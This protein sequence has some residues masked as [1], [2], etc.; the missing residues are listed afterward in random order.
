LIGCSNVQKDDEGKKEDGFGPTGI[1]FNHAYGV[2]DVRD[3]D[4][5]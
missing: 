4:G 1:L 5:L 2:L 3:I